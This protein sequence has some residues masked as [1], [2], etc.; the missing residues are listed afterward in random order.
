MTTITSA[1]ATD[2]KA[3]ARSSERTLEAA[4]IC[5]LFLLAAYLLKV[6]WRKWADPI[7]DSGAQFYAFWRLSR[8]AVLYHDL[9]WNY[10][11]VSAYFNAALF[12]VFGPGIM[13]LAAANLVVYALIATLAYAAVRRAWGA[14]AAF[15]ATAVF[16]CMF[17][18]LHLS[19]VGNYN[20]VLPYAH[21]STHGMLLLLVTLFVAARWR[22]GPSA[23]MAFSLGLCGGMSAVLKPEFML[24]GGVAGIAA[25]GLRYAERK[26]VT[27][28]EFA[29]L[30]AGLVV[31]TLVFT[32]WFVRLEPLGG[33]FIDAS[34]AW[35]MVLVDHSQLG[36]QQGKFIGLNNAQLNVLLQFEE[37]G[38]TLV[39]LAVIWAAGWSANLTLKPV[40]RGAVMVGAFTALWFLTPVGGWY[41][42]GRC[43]PLLVAALAILLVARALREWKAAGKLHER[44]VMALL[45]VLTAGTML[46]RMALF[47]RIYHLGF[48]QAALAGTVLAA[49][50]VAELPRWT[51]ANIL[52]C[53]VATGG[54]LAALAAGCFAIVTQSN[55]VYADMT[56]PVGTGRDAFYAFPPDIDATAAMVNWTVFQLKEIAPEAS[57]MTLPEGLMVNYLTR[58]AN[59]M[60]TWNTSISEENYVNRLQ[61]VPPD[62]VVLISRDH[63]EYGEKRFGEEGKP[64]H[65]ILT[66]V[67]ANYDRV[68]SAG[69]DPLVSKGPKGVIILRKKS[70]G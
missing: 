26:R 18:F 7:V 38:K 67:Y 30:A 42:I 15:A 3:R 17:S 6:S 57:L 14:M 65:Q 1:T 24:A 55:K 21:E 54:A 50:L 43:F 60:P 62:F 40:V 12:K 9:L 63:S 52:G 53:R 41:S 20:Y 48:F 2:S 8:G 11:P 31:P 70:G 34:R 37:T 66:W 47:P 45:L 49:A 33:A 13:V 28:L 69:G 68:T 23:G 27:M 44:T 29:M 36:Q 58:H 59:T 4:G 19:A 35:W 46:A 64:G 32:A 22:R 25:F 10:G 61:A 5:F 51:G 56:E 16:I 39:S